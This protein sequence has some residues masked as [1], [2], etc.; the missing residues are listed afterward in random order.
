MAVDLGQAVA[1]LELDTSGF[2]S[3]IAGAQAALKTLSDSSASISDKMSALSTAF[4][5]VGSTLTEYVTKPLLQLASGA[6][7]TGM[8]FDSQMSRVGAIAGATSEE[9][10]MLRQAA[11]QMGAD[12]VFGAT[13]A[14]KAMEYMGMAGWD[15]QEMI[16]GLPGIIN[17]AAASGEDLGTVSDIVTD[18][19]TAFGLTAADSAHFADVLAA[20]T[21]SSNTNVG[22]LGESFKYVAPIAGAMGYKIEDMSVALGLMANSGIKGS[23]A[24]TALRSTLVRLSKPTAQVA[25]AMEEY[26]ISLTNADGT[27]KP[28]SEVIQI[29]RDRFSGLTAAQ[30]TELAATLAGQE[31]MSGLLAIV[32]ASEEDYKQLTDAVN[33]CSGATQDMAD[34]MLDNLAGDVEGL[35][36]ALESLALNF[37]DWITPILR[38]AVEWITGLI[39]WLNDLDEGTRNM[40]FT[41]AAVVAAV[42]PALLIIAKVITAVKTVG[43]ALSMLT[44]P[45]GLVIAA[46]AAL[47]AAFLYLWNTNEG[48]RDWVIN[49]WAQICGFFQSAGEIIGAVWNAICDQFRSTADAAVNAW[50]GVAEFFTALWEGIQAIFEPVIEFFSTVFGGAAEGAQSGWSGVGEFFS[51]VWSGITGVFSGAGDWFKNTFSGIGDKIG[52]WFGTA[53]GWATDLWNGI[54]GAFGGGD[55]SAW[56]EGA[57]SGIGDKIGGWFGAAWS[58][59]TDLWN[60]ITGAFGGNGEG[61]GVSAWFESAFT[62]IGGKLAEWFG[63]GQGLID[64]WTG[65]QTSAENIA[66][67]ISTAWSN[68]MSGV[69]EAW[70]AITET[71]GSMWESARQVAADA[72]QAIADGYNYA[73]EQVG[74]AMDTAG[75]AISDGWQSTCNTVAGWFGWTAEE[76]KTSGAEITNNL[77]EGIEGGGGKAGEG[78]AGRVTQAAESVAE[79]ANDALENGMDSD[80]ADTIAQDWLGGSILG[81]GVKAILMTAAAGLAAAGASGAMTLLL[82]ETNGKGVG[83]SYLGG[84]IAGISGKQ[85]T[86]KSTA[87]TAAGAARNE[88]DNTLSAQNGTET[89]GKYI[90]GAQSGITGAQGSLTQ[91]A[92]T[93]GNAAADALKGAMSYD[94]GYAVGKEIMRGVQSGIKNGQSGVVSAMR[95]AAAAAVR[96]A[97]TTLE[98]HSPSRVFM[99]IGQMIP[100]GLAEGIESARA[101][102]VGET[103][104]MS[105]ATA[106]GAAGAQGRG[107]NAA[108]GTVQNITINSPR[109]LSAYEVARQLR[110]TDRELAL[111]WS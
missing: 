39:D 95:T 46:I 68:V 20:A 40:I 102:A 55:V 70:T 90:G 103:V 37:S 56:F 35:N 73:C 47:V 57:F 54:T 27:M 78:G 45:V 53:W 69:S 101:A 61:G 64:I 50:N 99:E 25:T 26:G 58:W 9:M 42:G 12:S 107:G 105:E 111:R 19:L 110:S 88:L 51:G 10:D 100:L 75:Q 22:M 6:L 89:G 1:Y 52:G 48:F 15:A 71:A 2:T 80:S 65:L 104:A 108:G 84:A 93:A 41:I 5:Q 3:G 91:A 87:Q 14:A 17:L 81:M 24:G 98:I 59:A 74:T 30:K 43:S 86:L 13:D 82:N 28:L 33:D 8:E 60:G 109:A 94:E 67:A 18:A 49:A 96:A 72:G 11:I 62:G 79:G 106:R 38:Q 77:A 97:K 66:T 83:E 92:Q 85:G 44:N 31:G 4:S 36:G 7:N 63:D 32:N 21:T 29:L 76:A 34:K 16:D 23:E